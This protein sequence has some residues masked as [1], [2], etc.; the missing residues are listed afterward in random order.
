MSMF[1]LKTWLGSALGADQVEPEPELQSEDARHQGPRKMSRSKLCILHM[2][3]YDNN[4]AFCRGED[5]S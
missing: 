4:F 5:R 3:S 2:I 1:I